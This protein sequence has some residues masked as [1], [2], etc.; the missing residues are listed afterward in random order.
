MDYRELNKLT[1]GNKYPLPRID[2]L[3]DQLHGATVF[4]QMDLAIGFHELRVVGDSIPLVA[5]R[6]PDFFFEW[7]I[8]PF[9]M[10]NAPSYFVNLMN[11]VFQEVSNKF[12]LVFIDDILIYS[13]PEE[14]HRY[15][16]E[17]VL[18]TLRGHV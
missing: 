13:K 18:E 4:F 11:C 3:F 10:T 17:V 7:L 14:E 1:I 6:G 16:L 12:V 5:L 8:M 15:H 9:G 2:D